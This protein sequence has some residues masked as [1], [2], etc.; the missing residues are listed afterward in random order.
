MKD[1][2]LLKKRFILCLFFSIPLVN[3]SATPSAIVETHKALASAKTTASCPENLYGFVEK[4]ALV[5]QQVTLSAKLDTGAKSASLNAIDI[6]QVEKDNKM[7]LRFKVLDKNRAVE[8]T[9]EYIGKVS[10]KTRADETLPAIKR[11]LVMMQVQIGDKIRKIP[12]NLT[13]RKHFNYPLL[14]GRDAIVAFAGVVDPSRVFLTQ[15]MLPKT[16]HEN[17]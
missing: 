16:L 3:A 9:C 2:M 4:A 7:Y 10:I 6:H 15:L 13:N 5:D 11:P 12:V 14:L 8:F 1:H 17:P